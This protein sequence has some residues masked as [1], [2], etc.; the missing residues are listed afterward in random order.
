MS[1]DERRAK[2][3]ADLVSHGMAARRDEHRDHDNIM[4]PDEPHLD[5]FPQRERY[6]H[7]PKAKP[8]P[9]PK[10]DAKAEEKPAPRKDSLFPGAAAEVRGRSGA[11]EDD[12]VQAYRYRSHSRGQSRTHSQMSH[13]T[14]ASVADPHHGSGLENG[15]HHNDHRPGTRASDVASIAPPI[16]WDDDD[17]SSDGDEDDQDIEE[18]WFPGGHAD[19]GGGWATKDGETPLSHV[20]LVWIVREAAKSGLEFD[21]D[22]VQALNC[23]DDSAAEG[24]NTPMIE[25]STSGGE[26]NIEGAGEN[27]SKFQY[28]LLDAASR[29]SLHDCLRFKTGSPAGTVIR[30]QIMEYIPFRRLDLRND[31]KWKAIRW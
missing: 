7:K 15:E 25:I 2:F 30:W 22:K 17:F 11:N 21:D 29:G 1:I 14:N 10:P 3:R 31:G 12:E 9:T 13:T 23:L 8:E 24:I 18:L 5:W 4:A 28:L 16:G 26:G 6:S 27:Q 19:I 20:P